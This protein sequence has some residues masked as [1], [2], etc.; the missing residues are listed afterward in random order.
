MYA[1][2]PWMCCSRFGS[3][4]A[5]C[6]K[7]V[8]ALPLSHLLLQ[9]P[10]SAIHPPPV[11]T[12]CKSS[13]HQL[14]L[15]NSRSSL[16]LSIWYSAWCAHT[17]FMFPTWLICSPYFLCLLGDSGET[18]CSIDTVTLQTSYA[19]SDLLFIAW[20]NHIACVVMVRQQ[21]PQLGA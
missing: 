6:C 11:S 10:P 4:M 7:Q 2:W 19:V 15:G 17:T 16:L 1:K 13:H 9:R 3:C 5:S 18:H 14:G 12:V 8:A 20:D 21:Q